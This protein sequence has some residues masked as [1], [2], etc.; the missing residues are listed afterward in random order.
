[1]NQT[2]GIECAAA[3]HAARPANGT[4]GRGEGA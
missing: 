1:M 3:P 4:V 2:F